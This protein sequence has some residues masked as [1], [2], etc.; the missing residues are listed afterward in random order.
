[1]LANPFDNDA[2][3]QTIRLLGLMSGM[4]AASEEGNLQIAGTRRRGPLS[5]MAADGRRRVV[6]S[7]VDRITPTTATIDWCDSMVC[8]YGDQVWQADTAGKDGM[9]ALSGGIIRRGDAIYR[10]RASRRSPLNADAMIIAAYVEKHEV[11]A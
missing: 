8:R 2:W 3:S 7:V 5:A 1:M 9:C 6:V 4:T 11:P 10:P